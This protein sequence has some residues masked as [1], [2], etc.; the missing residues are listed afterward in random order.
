M[1]FRSFLPVLLASVGVTIRIEHRAFTFTKPC[2]GQHTRTR[3]DEHNMP[4][5]ALVQAMKTIDF[6]FVRG[7]DLVV[8]RQDVRH[9]DDVLITAKIGDDGSVVMAGFAEGSR[10]ATNAGVFRRVYLESERIGATGNLLKIMQV[11]AD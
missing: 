10:N 9:Y 6:I 1:V 11:S 4:T 3:P 7:L 5:G 8:Y 2:A